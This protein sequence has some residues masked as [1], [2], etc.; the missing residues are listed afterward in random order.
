MGNDRQRVRIHVAVSTIFYASLAVVVAAVDF[1]SPTQAATLKV[2]EAAIDQWYEELICCGTYNYYVGAAKS[3]DDALAGN[4]VPGSRARQHFGVIVKSGRRVRQSLTY[5]GIVGTVAK[6]QSTPTSMDAV[7]IGDLEAT[8]FPKHQKTRPQVSA[9]SRQR[10]SKNWHQPRHFVGMRSPL[11]ITGNADP[12]P[13]HAFDKLE[14]EVLETNVSTVDAAHVQV[15]I[16][17]SY[18]EGEARL[19]VTFWT[20]PATPVVETIRMSYSRRNRPDLEIINQCG[21]FVDCHGLLVPR[22]IR[23]AANA[24]IQETKTWMAFEWR[25]DD[26]GAREPKDEDFVLTLPAGTLVHGI[27]R[28]PR[29]DRVS[30]L[31]LSQLTLADL[32]GEGELVPPPVASQWQ[33]IAWLFAGLT[34]L[35]LL[36]AWW[37][38]R[39]ASTA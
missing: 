15:T 30:K 16:R 25:S 33:R 32:V 31:D 13:L 18:D 6:E 27:K 22:T 4:Y 24:T 35:V 7:A 19:V 28:L 37:R 12:H 14:G 36:Y 20:E 11:N 34:A 5:A 17:K 2:L 23:S 9:E 3:V 38:W 8:F 10:D 1:A 26:L 39:A 21:D 29:S